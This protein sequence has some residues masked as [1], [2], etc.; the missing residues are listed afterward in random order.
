MMNLRESVSSA[1]ST[2]GVRPYRAS[3]QSIKSDITEALRQWNG[4]DC[5]ALA[6]LFPEVVDELRRL[7]QGCFVRE[8]PGHT[9]QPTALI[10]EV[11]LRLNGGKVGELKD[12]GQFFAF[13]ARLMR[14][15]LVDH[16]RARKTA[17]RGGGQAPL[18]LELALE[19][20]VAQGPSPEELLHLDHALNRLGRL[21]ARQRS[22]VE[23][24]Y[25]AG[26]TLEEIAQVLGISLAT[27][28][29]NWRVAR[30]WLARELS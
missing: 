28:E 18:G 10:N 13:A 9:L 5:E 22:V 24:R 29:H 4:E 27:V 15:I 3:Q 23:L 21:D 7:A 16:A 14:E 25:F 11:Y 6:R 12:R 17:K 20:P 8:D 19:V 26:L 2:G 1:A 30:R